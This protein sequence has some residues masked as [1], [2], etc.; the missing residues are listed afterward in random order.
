[1]MESSYSQPNEIERVACSGCGSF[2]RL[3]TS[4][5]ERV[6]HPRYDTMRCV[7]CESVQLI[8]D[9]RSSAGLA[10][11]AAQRLSR[12]RASHRCSVLSD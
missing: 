7:R 10:L 4:M 8:A 6:G 5:P 2:L 1:M 9:E 12:L 11:C 3:E